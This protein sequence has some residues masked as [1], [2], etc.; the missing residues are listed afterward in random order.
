MQNSDDVCR[1]EK[2]LQDPEWEEIARL[3]FLSEMLSLP[4]LILF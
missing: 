3:L 2:I 1:N 4:L